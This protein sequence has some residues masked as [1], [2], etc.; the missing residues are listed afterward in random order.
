MDASILH[1]GGVLLI[2][3]AALPLRHN[4]Y[5]LCRSKE[6]TGKQVIGFSLFLLKETLDGNM[7]EV[8]E[9]ITSNLHQ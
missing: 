5:P 2:G 7:E 9:L 6:L 4:L 3:H 8:E 1:M